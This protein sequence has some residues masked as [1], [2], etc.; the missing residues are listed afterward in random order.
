MVESARGRPSLAVG[1]RLPA[2]S[3]GSMA[4]ERPRD[5]V[6]QESGKKIAFR[7]SS[8]ANDDTDRGWSALK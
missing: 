8:Q 6:G 7:P 2:G 4:S 1:A 3:D 5:R